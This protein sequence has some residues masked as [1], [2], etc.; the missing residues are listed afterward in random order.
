[1]RTVLAVAIAVTLAVPAIAVDVPV[2]T[3]PGIDV[4]CVVVPQSSTRRLTGYRKV[5]A[6]ACVANQDEVI[7]VL[8]RRNGTVF[9][10]GNGRTEFIGSSCAIVNLCGRVGR[11]CLF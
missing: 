5:H 11:Y 2:D 9:C 8:L 10:T 1:M 4:G 3:V 7:V 6:V